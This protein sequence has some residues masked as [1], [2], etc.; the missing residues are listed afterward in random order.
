MLCLII[1]KTSLKIFTPGSMATLEGS[2]TL[3]LRTPCPFCG[4]LFARVGSHLAHCTERQG[5]DYSVYLAEKTLKNKSKSSRKSCPK[6][7][8][9]FLRLDT[10][11]KNSATCKSVSDDP[12]PPEQ[13]SPEQLTLPTPTEPTEITSHLTYHS[14]STHLVSSPETNR[15]PLDVLKLPTCQQ[16]WEEANTFLKE[17]VVP[18]VLYV[19]NP[20]DKNR[21]LSEGIYDY[22]A[23]KFGT[24]KQKPNRHQGKRAKHDRA[25]KKVTQLKNEARRE[26][27]KAKK[28]GL[29]PETIQPLARKFFELVREHSRLKSLSTRSKC[30]AQARS[31][32]HS[33][34]HHFWRFS[35]Q[36]LN[37]NSTSDVAPQ[38]TQEEACDYFTEVYHAGPR[39]FAQPAWMQ[40]PP[41]PTP[42]TEF[43]S[44]EIVVEEISRAIKRSKSSSSP[45][46]FDRISYLILKRCPSLLTALQDLFNCCWSQSTIPSQ[47]KLAAIKLIPK[48]SA[49]DDPTSPSN[50]RPIALT[51]CIGKLFTTILR[52][53]WL[54]Y[55]VENKF[56]DR[57]IQKAFMSATP[58]CIEHHCKL[59]AILAEARK[60]NKS[61][62]VCWLD[63]ANAYGS[64]HHFLI[65]FALRHY[66][67]PPQFCQTMQ[68]LYTDLTAK[69][70]TDQ[71]ATPP[72]PLS[73]G[74]Y[75][76]DPLS[77]VIFNTVIN[78]LVDALQTRLDL[79]YRLSNST[80]QVNVLQYADD[81]CLLADSPAA[82]QHL[83]DMVHQ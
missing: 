5:R 66:H 42:Q 49:K 54:T 23:K 79:G 75:Q 12:S 30:R 83:L 10:H 6:Y 38:F 53:R 19:T 17:Q 51:S 58:G 78:T 77:V 33:C 47:W 4:K 62:T 71:W 39:N 44:E 36:L 50:F 63:L 69:V 34:H 55:M 68:A 11:L 21:V 18:A 48:S 52:N 2:G 29:Q 1:C 32:R 70:I 9:M 7:H 37:D 59:G 65:Q 35:R 82:C 14:Q 22:F 76:G 8:R 67:A 46:P 60:R 57:S 43:D 20:D 72:V 73:I 40:T 13:T 15:V 27:Q 64:V 41:P 25:L 24:R 61:L 31:A 28:H 16:D 3:G 26:F 56:L 80:R 45:S 81:T 74:V